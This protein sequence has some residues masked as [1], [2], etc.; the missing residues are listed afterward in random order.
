MRGNPNEY[1]SNRFENRPLVVLLMR[2]RSMS[3]G[4]LAR[5]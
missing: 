4:Y 5:T 2:D 3:E 1:K